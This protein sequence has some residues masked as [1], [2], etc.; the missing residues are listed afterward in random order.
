M[1]GQSFSNSYDVAVAGS[2]PAGSISA[3]SLAREGVRVVVIEKEALPRHKTCG[4]GVVRR[5]LG[6]LPID[7]SDAI[8][9][10]CYS[11]EVNLVSTPLLFTSK[12]EEPMV[13]MTMRDSF[14]FL[15]VSAAKEAGA[16][17]RERCQVQDIMS[18]ADRVELVTSDG[19]LFSQFVVAADGANSIIAK[20]AGWKETRKLAPALE[21]EVVVSEESLERLSHAARFDFGLMPSGYAWTFPKRD[22]L[23]MG[24][25][26]M[27]PGPVKLNRMFQQYMQL[28]NLDGVVTI[29]RRG[30]LIPVS[31]R[32]DGFVKKRVLLSGDAAGLVDPVVGEGITSAVLSG[33]IAAKALLEGA[34]DE[35]NVKESY[36]SE[37]S[38]RVLQELRLGRALA[39][40]IYD[41]PGLLRRLLALYG[42]EFTE[43]VTDVVTGEKTYRRLMSTPRNYLQLFQIWH[44]K[45]KE[46]YVH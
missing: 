24:V 31:P 44:R 16:E 7:V 34:F 42:Q 21:C 26:S 22:H 46:K 14:D 28:I 36:E 12:R 38:K 19:S 32:K 6:L 37:L 35:R 39:K 43:A 27:R 20:K 5:A 33:M 30:S 10:E 11:A 15:L 2:G 13:S 4:G 23:S 8:E 17:V 9:R 1:I 25:L 40:L 41:Y 3:L 45:R 18:H 29:K